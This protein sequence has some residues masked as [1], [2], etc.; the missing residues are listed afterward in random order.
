NGLCWLA[1]LNGLFKANLNTKGFRL[2]KPYG[3][4]PGKNKTPALFQE[5]NGTIWFTT[6]RNL[7]HYDEKS[8]RFDQE[9]QKRDIPAPFS[10]SWVKTMFQDS[11]GWLWFGPYKSPPFYRDQ[12]GGWHGIPIA[13]G[14]RTLIRSI[15]EDH[16]GNIWFGMDFENGGVI[17]YHPHSAKI[18]T[19]RHV[20]QDSTSL[21]SDQVWRIFPDSR[22]RLWI[23]TWGEGINLFRPESGSFVRFK[24]D[25][26]NPHSIAGNYVTDVAEDAEG[27]IW[28][29]SWN[30]GLSR[31][32]EGDPDH[33]GDLRFEIFNTKNGLGDDLI[34]T[35]LTDRKKRLWIAH[36]IGLARFEYGRETFKNYLAEDGVEGM[37]FF[38]NCMM[39]TQSGQLYSGALGGVVNFHPDSLQDNPHI[40]PIQLTSFKIFEKEVALDTQIVYKRQLTLPYWQNFLSF[41]FAALDYTQPTLNQ[42]QYKLEG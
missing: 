13:T 32:I 6:N 38:V 26:R 10:T 29:G 20:P 27:R 16:E 41:S 19:F 11:R 5:K 7:H 9:V 1:T 35:L 25:P 31:L 34:C 24:A 17:R 12:E 18:D 23:T 3:E 28:F 8:G 21:S 30:S 42:Y 36:G 37:P 4:A 33:P 14:N 2:L 39:E 22:N 40:P 15:T